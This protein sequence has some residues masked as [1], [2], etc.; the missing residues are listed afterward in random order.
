MFH[1]NNEGLSRGQAKLVPRFIAYARKR[2]PDAWLF[3]STRTAR[4][5]I[6][7][8]SSAP[9]TRVSTSC[10]S[11]TMP[12]ICSLHRQREGNRRRA[13]AAVEN[14]A[15]VP[16]VEILAR[17]PTG[18]AVQSRRQRAQQGRGSRLV[19]YRQ[20]PRHPGARCR[21]GSWSFVRPAKSAC[22]ATMRWSQATMGDV[23]RQ[24]AGGDLVGSRVHGAAGRNCSANGR[25]NLK[26]CNTCDVLMPPLRVQPAAR[27]HA[28]RASACGQ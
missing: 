26:L 6:R 21:F 16:K 28:T 14:A 13:G 22:A 5:S 25:R 10:R 12:T 15:Y 18:S 8:S 20:V 19:D 24:S 23:T 3:R 4:R 1:S 17:R 11:T 9:W 27:S 7:G 2:C